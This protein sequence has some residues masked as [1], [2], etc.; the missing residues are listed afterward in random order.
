MNRTI[1]NDDMLV[2]VLENEGYETGGK[3]HYKVTI[4]QLMN[5]EHIY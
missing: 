1:L 5:N 4:I 2:K 3:A